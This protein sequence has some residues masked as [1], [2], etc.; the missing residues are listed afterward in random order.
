MLLPILL[1]TAL[2]PMQTPIYQESLRPQFHFTPKTGWTNDPNGLVFF[3]GEYHLFFQHNPFGTEW[4]NMTW[5]HAVS[6]DLV[7]W[8]QL[9]EAIR[10]DALGTIFS[11]SAVVDKTYTSALGSKGKPALVCIYTA[12]GGTNPESKGQPFTQC[13][14]YSLDGRTFTKFAGNP[15]LGHIAGENRDPKVVWHEPTKRWVMAL[16]LEGDKYALFGSP[17]LKSWTKLCDVSMPGCGECPDFFEM[18]VEGQRDKG[19]GGQGD[20]EATDVR[21]THYAPHT[22]HLGSRWVFWAANGRYR[23]GSFDGTV[24]KPETDVL[25]ADWGPNSYAAQTYSDAPSGRR[26]QISWMQGGQYPSMPFNQQMS[27]PREMALRETP[28]GPRVC[29]APVRELSKLRLASVSRRNLVLKSGEALALGQ[30]DLREIRLVVDRSKT[31]SL[32]LTLGSAAVSVDFDKQELACQGKVAPLPKGDEPIDLIGLFDRTS[33]EV[34]ACGGRV[35]M[36]GCFL[37]NGRP[38][39]SPVLRLE[40]TGADVKILRLESWTLSSIWP[41]K[42]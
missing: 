11:G 12:A 37:P 20:E 15:V 35:T 39:S 8:T 9:D 4:G 26:I 30:G 16:Y 23:L 7:H 2:H 22:T 5:G 41:P 10:P 27:F 31:G 17:D 32:R 34:F 36:A 19:T 21:T 18:K 38:L 1:A 42:G 29:M 40:A 33:A 14:A 6:K 24:F 28:D 13:L 25:Q 3:R